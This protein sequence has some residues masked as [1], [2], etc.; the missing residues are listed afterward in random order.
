LVSVRHHFSKVLPYIGHRHRNK[1]HYI[2]NVRAIVDFTK[3]YGMIKKRKI[4]I[5]KDTTA[6]NSLAKIKVKGYILVYLL[7][8]LNLSYCSN[9][10]LKKQVS[11]NRAHCD[12]IAAKQSFLPFNFLSVPKARVRE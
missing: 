7:F 3:S 1:I 4:N 9:S 11:S 8:F 12:L 6:K 10:V 5:K 2:T